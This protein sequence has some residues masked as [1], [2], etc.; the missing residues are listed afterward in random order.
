MRTAKLAAMNQAQVQATPDG[1][2]V[3]DADAVAQA[4]FDPDWFDPEYWRARAAARATPGGRGGAA[5]VDAPFG[6]CVL[7]HYRRG[8][9]VAR[10]LGDRY[11]WTQ[12]ERTR[13]FAEFRLLAALRDQD[14]P[15]PQ[16]IA[17]RYRR[18]GAQYRADIL[19]RRIENSVTL[20]ELLVQNRLDAV[21]AARVGVE[22]AR[23]QARGAYHADLNAHNILLT[24][25]M[26]WL[27]D[28]DRGDLRTPARAWQQMNLARLRRSLL[29]IGAA[30]NG[31]A[32]FE[33]GLWQPLLAAWQKGMAS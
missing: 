24:D 25:T 13:S 29:K 5:F 32:E 7:R 11:W 30:R 27:I 31:E 33:R 6:S 15:V 28:F 2:I 4:A 20:A 12:A 3:F 8:G 1:A 21:V 26:V 23:F 18:S 22:I 10:I 16:P 14:L 9:M 17:A 19:T